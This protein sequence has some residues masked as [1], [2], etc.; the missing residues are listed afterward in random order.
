MMAE[1]EREKLTAESVEGAALTFQG[2]HHVHGS[3]SLALGVLSVGDGIPDDVF[4]EHLEYAAG[5][6]VDEPRN[7]LHSTSTSQTTDGRFGDALDIVSQDLAVTL[8]AS[9]SKTLASLAASSHDAAA[10]SV[11][12]VSF[13][14]GQ[15]L[16]YIQ[17]AWLSNVKLE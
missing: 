8:S 16:I 3:D 9:L 13:E 17:R 1:R 11:V 5:L 4:Q 14:T 2:V 6:L 7:T 15:Q 12:S 10:A